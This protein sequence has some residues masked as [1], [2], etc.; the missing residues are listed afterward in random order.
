MKNTT[1]Q[2]FILLLSIVALFFNTKSSLSQQTA[3]QL[4]EKALYMEEAT[5]D[6]EQAIDLFQQILEDIP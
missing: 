1:K 2:F 5:G 3:G 4:F 6:L